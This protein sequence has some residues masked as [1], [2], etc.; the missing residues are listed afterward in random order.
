MKLLKSLLLISFITS[1]LSACKSSEIEYQGQCL[2]SCPSINLLYNDVSK[3]CTELCKTND[4]F[5]SSD[6]KCKS[7]CSYKKLSGSDDLDNFC[8]SQVDCTIFNRKQDTNIKNCYESCKSV[9]TSV[10]QTKYYQCASSCSNYIYED[11]DE[12]YCVSDCNIHGLISAKPNCIKNCKSGGKFYNDGK[13]VDSCS[14]KIYT[15]VNEDYC[16]QDCQYY[17]MLGAEGVTNCVESCI[18]IGQYLGYENSCQKTTSY[19]LFTYKGENY[20]HRD[21]TLFG[22]VYGGSSN[23]VNSCKEIGKFRYTNTCYNNCN[24]YNGATQLYPYKYENEIYCLSLQQCKNIG[25]YPIRLNGNYA[26]SDSCENSDCLPTCGKNEYYSFSDG[27]CI[28]SCNEKKLY[29]YDKYCIDSCPIFSPY[30]YNNQKENICLSKCP[31]DAPYVNY[32]TN[33]CVDTCNELPIF[34]DKCVNSCPPAANYINTVNDKKFCVKNC[35]SLG[36]YNLLSEKACTDNCKKNSKYLIKGNCANKCITEFPILYES[37]NENYCVKN[38]AEIGLLTDITNSKC[39]PNCKNSGYYLYEDRCVS[40][41]PYNVRFMYSTSTENYCVKSCT[42]VGLVANDLTCIES[43][44]KSIGK[45]LINGMCYQCP[46]G[47]AFKII[48]DTEDICT[49]NCAE[50]GLIPDYVNNKCIPVSNS[51]PSGQFKDLIN[52]SCVDKCP[53]KINFVEDNFCVKKCEKFYYE[54]NNG[55]KICINQC[56]GSYPYMVI[57]QKK[58]VSSCSSINNYQLNGYNICYSKCNDQ[59]IIPKFNFMTKNIFSTCVQNCLNNDNTKT[60]NDCEKDCLRPY[61]FKYENKCYQSCENNKYEYIDDQRNYLCI[62]TCKSVNK[63]FYEN[64]CINKCPENKKIKVEINGDITCIDYC[65]NNKL[66]VYDNIKNEYSCVDNC[67]D[68]NLILYDNKCVKECP[69]DKPFIVSDNNENKCSN[70]CNKYINTKIINGIEIKECIESCIEV[71]KYTN[72]KTCVEICPSIKNYLIQKNN[73]IF[74]SLSCNDEYKYINEENNNKFCLKSCKSLGKV[75]YNGKCLDKCPDDKSIEINK[76]SEIECSQNCGENEYISVQNNK[77][78]CVSD[79]SQYEQFLYNGKCVSECPSGKYLYEDIN[80]NKKACVEDCRRYNSY[81]ND[82]KCVS[83]CDLYNKF[84]YDGKC[85]SECP[86]G[87]Y[88]YEDTNNN[89]KICV[90]ECISYNLY[91]NGNKCVSNCD[92]YNK[93]PYDGKCISE[94]PSGKYLYEDASNNKKVC[95]EDCRSYNLYIN[96]NKCVI[97][98]NI[99]NKFAFEGKCLSKCPDDYSYSYEN[100]CKNEPCEEGKFYDIFYKKCFDK[101]DSINNYIDKETNFC[102]DSCKNIKTNNKV[103]SILKNECIQDCS[104]RNKY[105]YLFNNEYYCLDNC[106][107]NNLFISEDGKFCVEKCENETPYI[108]NNNQCASTC[109]DLYIDDKRNCVEKCPNSLPFI[110]KRECINSCYDNFLYLI[111]NTNI[112]VDS[113]N[114]NLVLNSENKPGYYYEYY[115][116]CLDNENNNCE[117][118]FY[119]K[120]KENRICYQN[121]TQSENIKYIYNEE[122]VGNCV[123]GIKEN[124]ICENEEKKNYEIIDKNCENSGFHFKLN[125]LL[126]LYNF[127]NLFFLE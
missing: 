82:D 20:A 96:D 101:C 62:D 44:C 84:N 4:L 33:I 23:C 40:S 46:A 109:G 75:V 107:E 34:D 127:I 13:C 21:C 81:N 122:C 39:I 51:C 45:T 5:R 16:A 28:N 8:L 76:N 94:C 71:N 126:F 3:T 119:L 65:P 120:D 30:I 113:C 85:L 17:N 57:N 118:P 114:S 38:C 63:I 116:K 78:I 123:Y 6:Y 92:L 91:I 100:I 52:N 26:C 110:Y 37:E 54:D 74:C 105:L 56:S 10:L 53:E 97:N 27:K 125:F 95:V 86:S 42:S 73:E 89:E 49:T 77:K 7:S 79:C 9:G 12:N 111:F 55:N 61:K 18:S 88:L 83:S 108:I 87:K 67:K 68:K 64:N 90:E 69:H 22:L 1:V 47:Y 93:F 15:T 36:L 59:S 48:G 24:Y 98:C 2:S 11:I 106:L 50:Y 25:K 29:L 112:C 121:C 58:C 70:E 124:N 41:C 72:E 102:I 35:N 117:K 60:E 31:E 14:K 43:S 80:N 66:M 115:L 19:N 99:F 32:E 103:F 104:E